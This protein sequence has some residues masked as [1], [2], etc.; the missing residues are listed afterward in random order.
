MTVE[1]DSVRLTLAA[2]PRTGGCSAAGARHGRG[3]AQ[4]IKVETP[5]QVD[6]GRWWI[7]RRR[8]GWWK[9]LL[10]N[11]LKNRWKILLKKSL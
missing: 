6:A 2:T 4:T 9:N 5:W 1:E 3:P 8:R 7:S 10:K 11:L